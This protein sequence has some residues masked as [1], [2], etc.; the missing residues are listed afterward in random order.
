MELG[1]TWNPIHPLACYL[2]WLTVRRRSTMKIIA[3]M[4]ES[5]RAPRLK[6]LRGPVLSHHYSTSLRGLISWGQWT[7]VKSTPT[8]DVPPNPL[9]WEWGGQASDFRMVTKFEL[10]LQYNCGDWAGL[11]TK[12]GRWGHSARTTGFPRGPRGP[13]PYRYFIFFVCDETPTAGVRT[14]ATPY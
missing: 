7:S 1:L 10:S 13:G 11:Q 5:L 14:S 3:T 9:T 2:G 8:L 12:I 6:S 4:L